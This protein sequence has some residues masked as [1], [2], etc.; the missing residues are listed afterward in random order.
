VQLHINIA[1]STAEV[2]YIAM[3][4]F[5]CETKPIENLMK[6]IHCIFSI[7]NP[8]TDFCITVH[9]DNLSGIA[10]AESLKFTPRTRHITI[11]YQHL[12]SRVKTSLNPSGNIKIKYISTKNQLV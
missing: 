9:E 7:P 12:R 6:E 3:S 4:H 1:L 10:M 5:L 8:M 2:D 11:K